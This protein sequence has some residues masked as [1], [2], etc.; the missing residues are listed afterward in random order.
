[1][2]RFNLI[3]TV[4]DIANGFI[5]VVYDLAVD[6]LEG[7]FSKEI[8]SN[9]ISISDESSTGMLETDPSLTLNEIEQIFQEFMVIEAARE[10]EIIKQRIEQND[11]RTGV[12]V[13]VGWSTRWG[14]RP[15]PMFFSPDQW[16]MVK[17]LS[18]VTHSS[19]DTCVLD[20][21][22]DRFNLI[23]EQIKKD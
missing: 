5:E 8:E 1:M 13:V 2:K 3:Q 12:M 20:V 19:I 17:E 21:A 18:I 23:S 15:L 4:K 14:V 16:T 6:Y 11:D 22:S 7:R 9:E 10:R